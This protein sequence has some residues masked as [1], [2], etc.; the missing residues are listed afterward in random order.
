LTRYLHW[1]TTHS[2]LSI[3]TDLEGGSFADVALNVS[4]SLRDIALRDDDW[5]DAPARRVTGARHSR[6][7]RFFGAVANT[8]VGDALPIVLDLLREV[9]VKG[10]EPWGAFRA[11]SDPFVTKCVVFRLM[12]CACAGLTGACSFMDVTWQYGDGRERRERG[13]RPADVRQIPLL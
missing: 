6:E 12:W 5:N 8:A 11:H 13:A 1:T 3:L 10:V 7:S 9:G 4:L 2:L